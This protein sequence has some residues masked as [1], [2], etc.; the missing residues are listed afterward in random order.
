MN[1][2]T[3]LSLSVAATVSLIA[4]CGGENDAEDV[5]DGNNAAP[6][7]QTEEPADNAEEPADNADNNEAALDGLEDE[8]GEQAE[9]PEPD[10]QDV[11]DVVAEVNGEEID[12]E[13]FEV[14]Y[15]GSF[16][17][18]AQQAQMTGE[19]IDQEQLK[20][21]VADNM[22]GTEL[23][24]Q[25]ANNQDYDVT[26]EDAEEL[27]EELAGQYGME[28]SDELFAALEEQGTGEEEI[29]N[30]IETQVKIERLIENETDVEEPSEEELEEMYEQLIEQQEQMGA[31]DGEEAEVPEFEEIRPELEQQMQAESEAEQAELLVEELRDEA[32]ITVHL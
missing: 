19:E 7:N 21:Q 29:M 30:Q 22:I 2:K 31:I 10:L 32:D 23:L 8:M 20:S 17:E 26:D 6:N 28:S 12:R 1:K 4:A 11:P 16:M 13:E 27:L 25:E 9:M 14:T 5:N 24:V 18:A 3:F 15:E